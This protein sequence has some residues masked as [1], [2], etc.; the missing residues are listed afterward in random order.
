M[1]HGT[2]EQ[3]LPKK[4]NT[5]P[6]NTFRFLLCPSYEHGFLFAILGGSFGRLFFR[7][8]P[9]INKPPI[10]EINSKLIT[11]GLPGA[12]ANII[13]YYTVLFNTTQFYLVLHNTIWNYTD[14]ACNHRTSTSKQMKTRPLRKHSDFFCVPLMNM[15]FFLPI[16]GGSFG[17]LFPPAASD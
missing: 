5:S 1:Q 15:D 9:V 13:L 10:K 2:T 16:L 6:P 4:E 8:R 14:A 11:P 7:R 17:R 3:A 12:P